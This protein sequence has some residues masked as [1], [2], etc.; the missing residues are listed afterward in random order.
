[1]NNN[2]EN[3]P[4]QSNYNCQASISSFK[5]HD[6]PSIDDTFAPQ[7]EEGD[8]EEERKVNSDINN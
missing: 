4:K 7:M 8:Q 6:I 2:K 5:R 1:M 3:I